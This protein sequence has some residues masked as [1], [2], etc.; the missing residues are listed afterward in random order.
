MLIRYRG[1][2][3]FIEYLIDTMGTMPEIIITH[4]RDGLIF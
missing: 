2:L 4:P 3:D 1:V